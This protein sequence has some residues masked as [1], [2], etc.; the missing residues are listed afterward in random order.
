MVLTRHLTMNGLR[1]AL[2]LH[3]SLELALFAFVSALAQ[4]L[5]GASA[6]VPEV[7]AHRLLAPNTKTSPNKNHRS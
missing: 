7:I 6:C 3:T 1:W 2:V 4:A 5:H